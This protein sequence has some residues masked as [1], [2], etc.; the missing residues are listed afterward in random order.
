MSNDKK[1]ISA[2]REVGDIEA[3]NILLK[4]VNEVINL[5]S[6]ID[7]MDEYAKL[8]HTQFSQP[9]QSV[10]KWVTDGSKPD[11]DVPVLAIDKWGYM[12]VAAINNKK[13]YP[14]IDGHHPNFDSDSIVGWQPLPPAPNK[15]I[16]T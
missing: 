10:D 16:K 1:P 3:E 6:V 8:Y 2:L 14:K 7:A 12:L 9:E 15:T 5:A 4:H 11:A 13:W